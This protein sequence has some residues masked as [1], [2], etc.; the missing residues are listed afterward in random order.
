MLAGAGRHLRFRRIVAPAFP[1]KTT[2]M[3]KL[4]T[5][6]LLTFALFACGDADMEAVDV[7]AAV[8]SAFASAYPGATDVEWEAD[9]DHYEVE[10]DFNGEEFELEY[11][12]NGELMEMHED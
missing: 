4:T 6:L 3:L 11:A 9:G 12:A 1:P 10:F 8:T 2:T 5:T 7:P